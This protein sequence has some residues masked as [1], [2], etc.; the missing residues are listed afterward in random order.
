MESSR[1]R[2]GAAF[3]MPGDGRFRTGGRTAGHDE[4]RTAQTGRRTWR[5]SKTRNQARSPSRTLVRSRPREA[6]PT[7]RPWPASGSAWRNR[8]RRRPRPTTSSRSSPRPSS[9][10]RRRRPRGPRTSLP[11]SRQRP[12]SPRPARRW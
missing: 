8:T 2:T 12:S 10:R 4:R 6:A 11:S 5:T 9:R 7:G 3:F 1:T